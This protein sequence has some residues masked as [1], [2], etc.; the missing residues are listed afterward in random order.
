VTN[1]ATFKLGEASESICQ[2]HQMRRQKGKKVFGT[3]LPDVSTRAYTRAIACRGTLRGRA[4]PPPA[5]RGGPP[6]ARWRVF[7]AEVL[8]GHGTPTLAHGRPAL[9]GWRF[10]ER[11]LT[12]RT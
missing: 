6:L 8:R 3:D 5:S 2:Y 4:Y 10:T 1:R 7:G 12:E 9:D 11:R